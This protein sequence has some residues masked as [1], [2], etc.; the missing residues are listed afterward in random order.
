MSIQEIPWEGMELSAHAI[1]I[2]KHQS[3]R[4]RPKRSREKRLAVIIPFRDRNIHLERL[5][6][7]LKTALDKTV[8][9]YEIY[10]AEQAD[11]ALFN[12]G[13]LCNAAIMCLNKDFDYICFHDVD[14]VP[15][16]ID[17]QY[18]SA[19]FR[20]FGQTRGKKTYQEEFHEGRLERLLAFDPSLEEKTD[21]LS[22]V[23]PHFWGGVF[24]L[25]LETFKK[26]NGFGN[27][28]PFWG[29]EDLDFLLRLLAQG[30]FPF[31]DL[32]G[33]FQLQ[34]HTHVIQKGDALVKKR[35]LSN[36]EYYRKYSKQFDFRG[37]LSNLEFDHF[38]TKKESSFTKLYLGRFRQKS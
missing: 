17:Y 5:L 33:I 10:V 14:F 26:V 4:P 38:Q 28:F 19:P 36:L 11:E 13:A 30:E 22:A 12:K 35:I 32:E 6:P 9:S 15:E 3:P 34:H 27:T 24:Q 1:H 29:F 21:C 23:Y 8:S 20:P 7:L 31:T 18:C 37:G 2:L 16:N 25:P